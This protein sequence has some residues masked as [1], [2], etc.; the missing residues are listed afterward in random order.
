MYRLIIIIGILSITSIKS[1]RISH[2]TTNGIDCDFEEGYCGY[3]PEEGTAEAFE[4]RNTRAS[5]FSGPS[6]DKTTGTGYFALCNGLNLITIDRQCILSKS[7]EIKDDKSRLSFWYYMYGKKI[8]T[9]NFTSSENQNDLNVLWTMT[10]SQQKE[11]LNAV[12]ELP[13]GEYNVKF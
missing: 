6:G 5:F 12:V 9:L 13:K 2:K 7:I 11:W 4:R 3:I 8:G 10:G 1:N